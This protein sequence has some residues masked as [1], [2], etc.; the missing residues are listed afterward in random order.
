MLLRPIN[1]YTTWSLACI[2]SWEDRCDPSNVLF[3]DSHDYLEEIKARKIDVEQFVE[4][5]T[6]ARRAVLWLS[7][8][9]ASDFNSN[10]IANTAKFICMDG[11]DIW[12]GAQS[13]LR[14]GEITENEAEEIRRIILKY[15]DEPRFLNLESPRDEP[16]RSTTSGPKQWWKFWGLKG[17]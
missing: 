2:S 6:L 11:N 12:M 5:R 10:M 7:S 17:R 15:H 1:E 14:K 9:D 16:V 3:R 4:M 8:V 13:A